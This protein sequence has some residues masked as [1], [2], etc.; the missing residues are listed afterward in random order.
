MEEIKKL[1]ETNNSNL[2]LLLLRKFTANN[3]KRYWM[4]NPFNVG[5]RTVATNGHCLLSTPLQQG[6]V[7]RSEK[8]KNVYPIKHTTNIQISVTELKQKLSEFPLLDCYDE[9]KIEC[10]ACNGLGMVEFEFYHNS[11][12]YQIEEQCPVCN[13]EGLIITQ[14]K[15]PNGKKVF[16]YNKFFIIGNSA[17]HIERI[18]ELIYVAEYLQSDTI[19]IANQT[20]KN[21]PTLFL[22]KDVELLVA[23]T[24]CDEQLI[25]QMISF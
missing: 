15:V 2:F 17:F 18:E 21:K 11:E 19:T 5:N 23:P 6:F 8:V 3:D 14:S 9:I 16:D 1:D 4:Q 13:G 20:E 12:T 10:D 22:I 7:D 24:L 25:T